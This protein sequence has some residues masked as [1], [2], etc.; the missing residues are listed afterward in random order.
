[1]YNPV[2][3]SSHRF[4]RILPPLV[5]A[6]SLIAVYL[7]TMAPGLTWANSGA[8]GGDLI[9]AAATGGVAHPTGYPTFLLIAASLSIPAD[10]LVG[11]PNEFNVRPGGDNCRCS[12]VLP[13]Q[14]VYGALISNPLL[15][16]WPR[17]WLRLRSSASLVVASRHHGSVFPELPVCCPH[18]LSIR[19]SPYPF[20]KSKAEGYLTGLDIRSGPGEPYYGRFSFTNP[21]SFEPHSP[22]RS[23]K[24]GALDRP[25]PVRSP[26]YSLETLMDRNWVVDL[27]VLAIKSHLPSSG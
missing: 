2:M 20:P 15:D 10:W 4:I 25:L 5:L 9:T 19:E 6:I 18:S 17:H 1:M 16:T 21:L 13:Y 24:R 3:Q 14:P 12:C 7:F 27:F 23:A 22:S 11:I 8:D 26:V